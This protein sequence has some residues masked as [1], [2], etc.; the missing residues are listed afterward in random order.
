[1]SSN[2]IFN[3]WECQTLWVMRHVAS[4]T[5]MA[6]A[7]KTS[8]LMTC[9][10]KLGTHFKF[11]ESHEPKNT[12]C[13]RFFG[14]DKKTITAC[15]WTTPEPYIDLLFVFFALYANEQVVQGWGPHKVK[16]LPW[17]GRPR[18]KLG[19]L[20]S[21]FL[22]Y[23]Y[24]YIKAFVTFPSSRLWSRSLIVLNYRIKVSN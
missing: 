15:M 21:F 7:S 12:F 6:N 17:K 22:I 11:P 4:T 20:S 18:I 14:E 23:I 2:L 5:L 9:Q 13:F 1:M 10:H 24:I 8:I 16:M 19:S 3:L